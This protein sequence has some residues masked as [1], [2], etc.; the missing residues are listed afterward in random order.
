M[1]MWTRDALRYRMGRRFQFFLKYFLCCA[2]CTIAIFILTV[3][4]PSVA[5]WNP[6]YVSPDQCCNLTTQ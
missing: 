1:V 4:A 2:G 6:L 3:D 5:T